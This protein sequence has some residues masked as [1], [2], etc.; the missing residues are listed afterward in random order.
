M[1]RLRK[2]PREKNLQRNRYVLNSDQDVED[3]DFEEKKKK[4]KFSGRKNDA[5]KINAPA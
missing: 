1:K 5:G 2:G 3:D 4:R